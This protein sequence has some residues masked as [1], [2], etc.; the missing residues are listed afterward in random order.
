MSCAVGW[1]DVK[2][3]CKEVFVPKRL[4]YHNATREWISSKTARDISSRFS[5]KHLKFQVTYY[6]VIT[7][8]VI[9]GRSWSHLPERR[10]LDEFGTPL[11]AC[12]AL[13]IGGDGGCSLKRAKYLIF[14]LAG[15]L[16]RSVSAR[17]ACFRTEP[18]AILR[19]S[20]AVEIVM[21][22]S[23][24][25]HVEARLKPSACRSEKSTVCSHKTFIKRWC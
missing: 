14:H 25:L 19:D 24:V 7:D 15:F 6:T 11:V 10:V 2:L 5:C 3:H 8:D 4:F 18:R 21:P 23:P 1:K 13:A 9:D 12:I 20:H 16:C 22:T 17:H